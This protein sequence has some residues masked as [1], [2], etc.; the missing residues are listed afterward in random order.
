L[1]VLYS[2]RTRSCE[3][4]AI[5]E[6]EPGHDLTLRTVFTRTAPNVAIE[7]DG[8]VQLPHIEMDIIMQA[9]STITIR[10]EIDIAMAT[11]VDIV[12]GVGATVAA[13]VGALREA[14][15]TVEGGITTTTRRVALTL[16]CEAPDVVETTTEH[17]ATLT[18]HLL[19]SPAA[20]HLPAESD[21][22]SGTHK[23]DAIP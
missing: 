22:M 20:V 7:Q 1:L 10:M 19:R 8:G 4:N 13:G 3:K 5:V 12:L 18:K 17:E 15:E 2:K 11:T 23:L 21:D 16:L 9:I 6:E 14:A